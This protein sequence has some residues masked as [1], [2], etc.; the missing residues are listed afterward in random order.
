MITVLFFACSCIWSSNKGEGDEARNRANIR[1]HGLDFVDAE[2]MFHGVLVSTLTRERN[3]EKSA[4]LELARFA[5]A[6]RTWSLRNP[7]RTP[8]ESSQRER[9]LVVKTNNTKRRSRTDW[10]RVDALRDEDIEFSEMSELGPDFFARAILW[11]EPKKQ[12]NTVARSWRADL[13]S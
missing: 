8:F 5:D 9:Q 1:K 10:K 3:T 6:P 4:G 2:E 12:I 13:L 7:A 11:P